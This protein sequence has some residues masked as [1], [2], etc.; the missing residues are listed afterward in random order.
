MSVKIWHASRDII[1]CSHIEAFPDTGEA[2]NWN[3]LKHLFD[4]WCSAL[5]L[6]IVQN[7]FCRDGLRLETA[8][9]TSV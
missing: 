9:R 5:C 2:R 1:L 7:E 8:I 3:G 4:K 6:D